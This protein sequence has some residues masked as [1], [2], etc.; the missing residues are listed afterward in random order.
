MMTEVR[1]TDEEIGV[2][3]DN[4]RPESASATLGTAAPEVRLPSRERDRF[5]VPQLSESERQAVLKGLGIG[6]QQADLVNH[7]RLD[8]GQ[9]YVSGKGY[10]NLTLFS[11]VDC[12][13]PRAQWQRSLSINGAGGILDM[14]FRGLTA[15]KQYLISIAVSGSKLNNS[16]AYKV[17]ST[18]DLHANFSVSSTASV[19]YLYGVIKPTSNNCLV[20]LEPIQ[21]EWFAFYN[22]ELSAL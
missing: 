20:R 13:I 10:I 3:L 15:N 7:V 8:M 21:L 5:A 4:L 9:A 22:V 11:N 12:D 19:Q 16:G 1:R 18:A 2:D 14:A 17:S 6:T